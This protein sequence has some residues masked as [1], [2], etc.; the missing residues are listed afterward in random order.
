MHELKKQP[1][2][3]AG[4]ILQAVVNNFF[5]HIRCEALLVLQPPASRLTTSAWPLQ[6]SAGD[7][8]IKC[9]CNNGILTVPGI[10]SMVP[11]DLAKEL[12]K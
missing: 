6:L 12:R 1:K 5:G 4:R 9:E 8:M 3:A 7:S 10:L 2:E 11:N